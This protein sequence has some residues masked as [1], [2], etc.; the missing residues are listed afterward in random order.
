MDKIT[1][2]DEYKPYEIAEVM[3][4]HCMN[5]VHE[6]GEWLAKCGMIGGIIYNTSLFIF[7]FAQKY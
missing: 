6:Q 3:C 1:N 7:S 2:I 4:L 5:P